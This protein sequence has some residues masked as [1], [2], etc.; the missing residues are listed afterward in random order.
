MIKESKIDE[1]LASLNG[2]RISHLLVCHQAELAI[3]SEAAAANQIVDL[4]NLNEAVKMMRT[5]DID[6]FS[7]KIIDGQINTMFLGS[8]MHV[9]MQTMKG[10]D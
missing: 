8:N 1:L 7:S 9:M 5:E 10:G 4:T 3:R 2:L 6:A